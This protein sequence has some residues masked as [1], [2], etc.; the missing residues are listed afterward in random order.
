MNYSNLI[1]NFQKGRKRTMIG[2][3]REVPDII[4]RGGNQTEVAPNL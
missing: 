2:K 1:I 3:I 4:V